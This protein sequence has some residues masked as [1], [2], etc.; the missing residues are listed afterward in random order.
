ML[1]KTCLSLY[2]SEK[3]EGSWRKKFFFT[4]REKYILF[5][6]MSWMSIRYQV[7]SYAVTQVHQARKKRDVRVV[8]R[9][10]IPLFFLII[11]KWKNFIRNRI[12]LRGSWW[13]YYITFVKIESRFHPRATVL[14]KSLFSSACRKYTVIEWCE[15][16]FLKINSFHDVFRLTLKLYETN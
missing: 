7:A 16:I 15:W 8:Q 12:F 13:K 1:I 6:D 11:E 4:S 10:G 5:H 2:G 14:V 3:L 9:V